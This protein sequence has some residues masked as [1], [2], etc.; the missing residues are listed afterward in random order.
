MGKSVMA[1]NLTT[2][3]S[4]RSNKKVALFSLEMN[5]VSLVKRMVS[6]LAKV[7]SYDLRDGNINDKQWQD[8]TKASSMLVTDRIKLYEVTMSLN[9]I[10]AECKRLSIQNGLDVVIIDYLQLIQGINKENR[11]QEISVI[12][13][14]LN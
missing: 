9:K 12:S 14:K 13:R 1:T 11:T 10:M 2:N 7:E 5:S 3:V 8:I 4:L 6:N